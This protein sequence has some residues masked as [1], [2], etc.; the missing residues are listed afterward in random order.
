MDRKIEDVYL[1]FADLHLGEDKKNNLEYFEADR[2]FV[3]TVGLAIK[4]YCKNLSTLTLC[5]LGDTFDFLSVECWGRTRAEETEDAAIEQIK[6]IFKAHRAVIGILRHFLRRGGKIKFFIGNH[7]LALVWPKVQDFIRHRLTKGVNQTDGA[8]AKE[9]IEFLFEEKRDGV[10]LNHGNNAEVLHATPENV[11]LTKRMGQPLPAPLLRH[12]YGNHLRTDLA[13]TLA[14]GSKI[15]KGNYWVGRLEPHK[16]VF[17]ESIWKPQNWWFAINA[18][19]LWLIMPLRYQFSRRWWVRKSAGLLTLIRYNFEIL[20]WTILNAMRGKDYTEYPKNILKDNDDIDIVFLGHN[21]VCRR[22][23]HEKY[24]T[25]IYIGNWST[26]FDV[27]FPQPKLKWKRFRRFERIIKGI[28]VKHKM[29]NK[30]T[31]KLYEPRRRELYR[32]GVC[33]FFGNGYKEIKLLKYNK[34]ND[35]LEEQN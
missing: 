17:L 23:M 7:D 35:T 25:Y 16:Y 26:I 4:R 30:K 5:L 24:G 10:Y 28:I 9:R 20:F 31:R 34:Q 32:F 12:P 1:L 2:E 19:F 27:Q 15:C 13:N 29:F 8:S 14:R 18:I 3:R 11:F 22:E 21:H 6:K 33:K